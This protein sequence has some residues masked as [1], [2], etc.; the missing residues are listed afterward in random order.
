MQAEIHRMASLFA[1][2]GLP[3]EP[4]AIISFIQSH[5]LAANVAI[6]DAPF[7]QPNQAAFIRESLKEDAEWCE[8]IDELNI[9][10]H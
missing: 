10:L 4:K 1:Q 8:V 5:K 2:L 7:W 3:S 9:L 6:E